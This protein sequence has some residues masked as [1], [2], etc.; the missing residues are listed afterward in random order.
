VRY[1]WTIAQNELMVCVH[2]LLRTSV[3]IKPRPK[4]YITVTLSPDISFETLN[5]SC[6]VK[7]V[8]TRD[9]N[10]APRGTISMQTIRRDKGE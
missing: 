3:L 5:R 7:R 8:G 10:L 6:L 9:G 4:R 1:H 2:M